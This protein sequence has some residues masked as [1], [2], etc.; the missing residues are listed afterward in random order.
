MSTPTTCASPEVP[1]QP[2]QAIDSEVLHSGLSTNSNPPSPL[3]LRESLGFKGLGTLVGGYVGIIGIWAFL[4]FLWFGYGT[5]PDA[6]EASQAWRRI[7]LSNWMTRAITLCSLAIRLLVAFHATVC[8]SMICALILEK[9]SARKSHVPWIS[10]MRSINDGPYKLMQVLLSSRSRAIVCYPEFWL[11][12][13]MVLTVLALQFS[14]TVLLSD[15]HSSVIIGDSNRTQVPSL[16]SYNET[17]FNLVVTGYEDLLKQPVFSPFGEV[18]STADVSPNNDGLSDTGLLQRGFLPF[19]GNDNRT[20]AK[21]YKGNAM[22]MNLRAACMRPVI[23]A[24][25][26]YANDSGNYKGNALLT[27]Q[28]KYTSS[29]QQAQVS[30]ELP[31]GR[32]ECEEIPFSCE[33]PSSAFG[34]WQAASCLIDK[35]GMQPAGL[36][37]QPYWTPSNGLW[38]ANSSA[39]LVSATNLRDSDWSTFLDFQS[40]TAGKPYQE[41][42]S[43]ELLPGRS[44]NLSLCFTG[45]ELERKFVMMNTSG[46]LHEPVIRGSPISLTYDTTDVRNLFGTGHLRKSLSAPERGTLDMTIIGDPDDGLASSQAYETVTVGD[47]EDITIARFTA[48]IMELILY[49]QAVLLGKN[50]T[51]SFCAFCSIGSDTTSNLNPQLSMV[52]SDIIT[53]SGRAADAL[54]TYLTIIASQVY[55]DYLD[56]LTVFQEA[57]IVMTTTVLVP[58]RCSE[59]GCRGFISVTTLLGVHLLYVGIIT[60][61]YIRR[62]R[63]SRYANIWHAAS[64]L[65]SGELEEALEQGNNTSDEVTAKAIRTERKDDLL[66]LGPIEDT[67]RIGFSKG[68]AVDTDVEAATNRGPRLAKLKKKLQWNVRKED[69]R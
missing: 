31:C 25:Y 15:L 62:I 44:L 27:G 57:D 16:V 37:L 7:A 32:G 48:A 67:G 6:A 21:Q 43:Y 24:Q 12:V 38:S 58:G 13:S 23:D 64:Q 54:L 53:E 56:A 50:T 5:T 10:V 14:S 59:Q 18:Q 68:R 4:T 51:L 41:W 3:P 22:I 19:S 8:T 17:D 49:S 29:L 1:E 69:G 60:V 9:H 65:V 35:F 28:V 55:Y 20:S 39:H 42:Q 36:S 34:Q 11:T 46:N 26:R 45:V 52:L 66:H 61:L 47:A 33:V 30:S 40:L 63:Y 2:N